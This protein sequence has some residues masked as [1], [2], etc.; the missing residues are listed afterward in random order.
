MVPGVSSSLNGLDSKLRR[1]IYTC[2][3]NEPRLVESLKL[4]VGEVLQPALVDEASI[5]FCLVAVE[6]LV[7]VSYYLQSASSA[8]FAKLEYS[9]SYG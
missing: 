6:F 7:G 2:E 8:C 5:S 9:N 1:L 4:V 3:S